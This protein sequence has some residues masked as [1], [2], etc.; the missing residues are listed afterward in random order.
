VPTE[1]S[2]NFHYDVCQDAEYNPVILGIPDRFSHLRA[3]VGIVI[4]PVKHR[5]CNGELEQ[6]DQDFFHSP[7]RSFQTCTERR[8]SS[9]FLFGLISQT[10][11]Q[12][13]GRSGTSFSKSTSPVKGGWWSCAGQMQSCR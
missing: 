6:R 9:G 5:D 11:K 13:A 3:S 7:K 12:F 1:S 4:N 2:G 10:N 8:M